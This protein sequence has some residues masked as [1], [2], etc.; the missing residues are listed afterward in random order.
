MSSPKPFHIGTLVVP[1]ELLPGDDSG[2]WPVIAYCDGNVIQKDPL[3]GGM[4][5]TDLDDLVH[6]DDGSP[7]GEWVPIN[8]ATK[9][10]RQVPLGYHEEQNEWE[11]APG[12]TVDDANRII[13]GE[14][15]Q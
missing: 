5:I 4:E 14:V 7:L 2:G 6:A 12:L 8:P 9:L 15:E 13:R 10:V 3:N 11:W 1:R